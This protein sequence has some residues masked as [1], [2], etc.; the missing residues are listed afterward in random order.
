MVLIHP[1]PRLLHHAGDLAGKVPMIANMLDLLINRCR[2]GDGFDHLHR[3]LLVTPFS[4]VY[5]MAARDTGMRDARRTAGSHRFSGAV[6]L[7]LCLPIVIVVPMSFS[8][9]KS[10]Q[11]P[12]GFSLRWYETLGEELARRRLNSILWQLERP[13]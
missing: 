8:S 9:A 5:Q 3:L 12:P 4:T 7:F 2:A 13:R 10:L 6:L 11:F 1:Q